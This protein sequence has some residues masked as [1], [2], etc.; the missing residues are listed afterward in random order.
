M[1][2]K[3]KA[4]R[5]G[6]RLIF[7]TFVFVLAVMGGGIV[8]VLV[9]SFIAAGS[10]ILISLWVLFALFALYFFRDPNPAVPTDPNA[11]VA[12]AHGTV[13]A[14]DQV[15][16]LEYMGGLCQRVSVFLSVFDVHVQKAPVAGQVAYLQ[17]HPGE[18]LNAMK[19][20]AASQNE[21]LL[22]GF[23]S[24]EHEGEKIGVRLVAGM[25]ARRIVPWVGLGDVVS[26]GERMSLIQFGSR[27]DLYLP[28]TAKIQVQLG[29]KMIGGQTVV[30]MRG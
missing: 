12:V 24:S 5:A 8:A 1:K 17:H 29:D 14:I 16:E 13:D 9:G 18:F 20:E 28:L 2:H 11:I 19:L 22:V 15:E 27:C 21:N 3:G 26:R 10:T 4:W 6:L 25:I 30:A 7:W 23:A